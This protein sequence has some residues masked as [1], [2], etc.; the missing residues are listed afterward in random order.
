VSAPRRELAA[1]SRR[2]A[3]APAPPDVPAALWGLAAAVHRAGLDPDAA[4]RAL[5]TAAPPAPAEL[6][7]WI[8][9]LARRARR[10]AAEDARSTATTS[11]ATPR[12]PPR[13]ATAPCAS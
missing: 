8:A 9:A 10:R 4:E 6:L 7:P 11:S 3:A 12:S 5:A 1:W 2:I 13:S